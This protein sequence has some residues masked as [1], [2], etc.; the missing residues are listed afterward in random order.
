MPNPPWMEDAN[1][2]GI[3]PGLQEVP[4]KTETQQVKG[5]TMEKKA[6]KRLGAR[7]HSNSGA[8]I[9][10]EDFSTDEVVYEYK[11]VARS[12]ALSGEKLSAQ[13]RRSL[14][15]GKD[16]AYVVYFE[17]VDVTLDGRIRRGH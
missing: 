3:V 14:Q 2:E 9:E 1:A 15:Q 7:M 13:L 10:K 4:W 11:N 17:D 5:R 6:A 8:G 16:A 12:H